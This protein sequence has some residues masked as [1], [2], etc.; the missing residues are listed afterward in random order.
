VDT[1]STMFGSAQYRY[2]GSNDS[3]Y[4]YGDLLLATLGYERS[5]GRVLDGVLEADFRDAG[6][7]RIDDSGEHDPDT[8][9][10]MLYLT[11]RLLIRLTPALVARV[12]AQIPV[13]ESLNGHQTEHTV[14]NAGL[15]WTFGP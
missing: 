3:G 6:E 5:L 7:D 1:R 15:T 11:P 12:S 2:T 8:G 4:R 14:Y 13:A 10:R 9:G